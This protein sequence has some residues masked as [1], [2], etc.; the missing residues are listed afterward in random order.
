MGRSIAIELQ[1]IS[2]GT[3]DQIEIRLGLAMRVARPKR[4]RR[5]PIVV[6]SIPTGGTKRAVTQYAVPPRDYGDLPASG[7]VLS[8]FDPCSPLTVSAHWAVP[9]RIG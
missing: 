5:N 4:L 8:G 3:P 9:G 6:G 1:Q 2:Q 7:A